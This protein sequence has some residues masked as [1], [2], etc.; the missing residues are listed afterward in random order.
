M[1]G[2]KIRNFAPLPDLSLVELVPKDNFYRRLVEVR[3]KAAGEELITARDRLRKVEA[4]LSGLLTSEHGH[5]RDAEISA[6][7]ES[8]GT[9][10]AARTELE[11]LKKRL[12]DGLDASLK[13]VMAAHESAKGQIWSWNTERT[14][15][16]AERAA[17][18]K[19][20]AE[21]ARQ[22]MEREERDRL[23]SKQKAV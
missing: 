15:A 21:A 2:T 12:T 6:F 4:E 5:E 13:P 9:A 7:R 8:V 16:L 20:N 17:F 10:R 11:E 23:R 22:I 19:T 3:Y 14:T 18:G 1:M